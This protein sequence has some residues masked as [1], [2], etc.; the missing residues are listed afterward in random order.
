[1]GFLP[2]GLVYHV[3]YVLLVIGAMAMLVKFA[4]PYELENLE[5]HIA[6]EDAE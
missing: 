6:Q 2:I 3:F 5:E 1:M 4:W